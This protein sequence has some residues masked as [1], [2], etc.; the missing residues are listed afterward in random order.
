MYKINMDSNLL[1]PNP[2]TRTLGASCGR[3]SSSPTCSQIQL[4]MVGHWSSFGSGASSVKLLGDGGIG[5]RKPR[6]ER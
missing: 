2:Q 5:F 6:G 1:V 4:T 3:A